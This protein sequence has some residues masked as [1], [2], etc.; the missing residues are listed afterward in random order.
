LANEFVA[1]AP[2]VILAT[3][4]TVAP[5]LQATRDVP[6]VFVIV[7][8]PVGS[9]FVDSLDSLARQSG[10]PP[11]FLRLNS[12]SAGRRSG[13]EDDFKEWIM[14]AFNTAALRWQLAA[15]RKG[16]HSQNGRPKRRNFLDLARGSIVACC[17]MC[18]AA[19]AEESRSVPNYKELIYSAVKSSFVDPSSIGLVEISSL[20]PS[21]PPQTGDWMACLRIAINGQPTLY[22]AFIEGQPPSVVLLRRAVRF[23]DCDHDQYDPLPGPPPPAPPRK[24]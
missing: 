20:H 12:K 2:E 10:T 15:A 13:A 8:D 7:S 24:K 9:G 3:G 6:I 16:S 19:I 1:V 23:D 22:A 14:L 21:R 17:S 5:L 11:V 18:G 4:A